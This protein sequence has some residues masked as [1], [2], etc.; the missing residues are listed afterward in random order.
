MGINYKEIQWGVIK[1]LKNR[2]AKEEALWDPHKQVKGWKWQLAREISYIKE[3]IETNSIWKNKK[4]RILRPLKKRRGIEIPGYMV[5][6]KKMFF[7][8][9]YDQF[10]DELKEMFT[11]MWCSQRKN[12][13]VQV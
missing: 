4:K 12:T 9:R 11:E 7:R 2:I 3:T 10:S 8:I 5:W 1:E 13:Y 6:S